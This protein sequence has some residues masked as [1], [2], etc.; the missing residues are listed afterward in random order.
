[1]QGLMI[2][3]STLHLQGEEVPFEIQFISR[4]FLLSRQLIN[5]KGPH[6][7]FR[8]MPYKAEITSLNLLSPSPWGQK[9]THQKQKYHVNLFMNRLPIETYS[10]QKPKTS[11]PR[12]LNMFSVQNI[13]A[14]NQTAL[15]FIKTSVLNQFSLKIHEIFIGACNRTAHA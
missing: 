12:T 1:M 13:Q 7:W 8:T 15:F 14:V 6:N 2:S 9:L 4:M 5:P 11:F 10:T 3:P